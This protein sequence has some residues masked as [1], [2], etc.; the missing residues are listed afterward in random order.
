MLSRRFLSLLLK[1]LVLTCFVLQL[2]ACA[3]TE[4]RQAGFIKSPVVAGNRK[5]ATAAFRLQGFPYRY[6]GQSPEEGFDCS[7]LVQYVYQTQGI[8]LP[9]DTAS[10][11]YSLPAVSPAQRLPG[12]LVFFNT[13]LNE[14]F[15]HVGIYLGDDRFVH[16]PSSHTGRVMVS[17]LNQPYWQKHFSG[18]RRPPARQTVSLK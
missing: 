10:L 11:A 18:V 15:S 7:G 9:R 5:A 6:G 12:D 14:S 4:K 8:S 17:D 16:A 13:T 1:R 2:A 3:N